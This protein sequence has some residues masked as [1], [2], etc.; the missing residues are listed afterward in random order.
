VIWLF[1]QPVTVQ[2]LPP[3][4]RGLTDQPAV[5]MI[6]RPQEIRMTQTRNIAA[7]TQAGI[8]S[9]PAGIIII[10]TRQVGGS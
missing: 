3:A 6:A 1:Q 5:R 4:I 9:I 8:A 10:T 7:M 2:I